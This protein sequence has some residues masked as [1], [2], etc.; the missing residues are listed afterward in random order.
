MVPSPVT[1]LLRA[2][3]TLLNEGKST[4]SSISDEQAVELEEG[5][6]TLAVLLNDALFA[7]LTKLTRADLAFVYA[8]TVP[9]QEGGN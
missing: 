2:S 5:R 4:V 7:Q 6:A 8:L 3:G 9:A 1:V